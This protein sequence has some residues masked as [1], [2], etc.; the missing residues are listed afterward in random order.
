MNSSTQN[1][2]TGGG[3]PEQQEEHVY[4]HGRIV[5]VTHWLNAVAV[6]ALLL[7]GFGITQLYTPLHWGDA[8]Q[9]WGDVGQELNGP[10]GDAYPVIARVPAI[11]SELHLG[12]GIDDALWSA[13]A[14]LRTPMRVRDHILFAWLFLF[15]GLVYLVAGMFTGRF[16]GILRPS[17][18]EVSWRKIGLDLCSHLRLQF[19][20]G[21]EARSYNLI[22]KY[23]YLF[24]IFVALPLQLLTGLALLPWMD[25]ALPWL[26]DIFGGRQSARTLH[27]SCS[28]L[29]LAFV[30]VHLAM[31]VLS[32][33]RNNMR[34]MVTGWYKLPR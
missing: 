6:F 31:V 14:Y 23:A 11:P 1:A 22:Q 27:F 18:R 3:E 10:S 24:I 33:F 29:V 16:R 15:N 34:S 9:D 8:G 12:P 30:M 20:K 2:S 32:G 21:D 17:W 25:G 28:L 19:A 5:R 4:R 13:K 26:K 7:T